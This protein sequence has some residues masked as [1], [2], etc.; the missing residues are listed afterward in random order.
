MPE[1]TIIEKF[2]D[3]ASAAGF[4]VVLLTPDDIGGPALS[5]AS[6]SEAPRTSERLDLN[7]AGLLGGQ[8]EP[9]V[10]AEERRYRGS[11]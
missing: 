8:P 4:A 7:L 6:Q 2:E 9:S 10:R 3:H 1:K 5:G 11:V